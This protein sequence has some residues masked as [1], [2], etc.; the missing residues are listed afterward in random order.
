MPCAPADSCVCKNSAPS[1]PDSQAS[2]TATYGAVALPGRAESERQPLLWTTAPA[3]PG[4]CGGSSGKCA[5]GNAGAP[6]TA[7]DMRSASSISTCVRTS[8]T[9]N[10]RCCRELKGEQEQR[11][12]ID[13]DTI[14]DFIIGLSD[15][16]T[17]RLARLRDLARA[18][19][20]P[21]H[22]QLTS[23]LAPGALCS[24]CRPLV[25]R[26][27]QACRDCWCR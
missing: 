17:V 19:M 15:G 18:S 2:S 13:P 24:D 5:P 22:A 23:V 3:K 27:I 7:I 26:V 10:G 25:R 21:C 4:C 20:R 1:R 9:P 6:D 12:L 16:L 14:R 8:P 11:A